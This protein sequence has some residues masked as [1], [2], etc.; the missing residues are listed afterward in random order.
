MYQIHQLNKKLHFVMFT[1]SCA[2]NIGIEYGIK[3][4]EIH[5]E[6]LHDYGL[7]IA[8]KTIKKAGRLNGNMN[9]S[10]R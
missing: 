4:E 3:G 8:T 6:V 1:I 2:R 5:P 10:V 7:I 9:T